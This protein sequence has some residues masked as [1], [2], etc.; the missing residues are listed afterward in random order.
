[1]HILL[2]MAPTAFDILDNH[3]RLLFPNILNICIYLQYKYTLLNTPFPC[4][5]LI[6]NGINGIM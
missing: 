6:V 2:H 4:S 1:M 3:L 5:N